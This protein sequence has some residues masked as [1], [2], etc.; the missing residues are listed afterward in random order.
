MTSIKSCLVGWIILFVFCSVGRVDLFSGQEKSWRENLPFEMPDLQPPDFPDQS[1]DIR[2]FGADPDDKIANTKAFRDAIAQCTEK[3]GGRV[4]VPPGEWLTGPIHLESNVDLHVAKDAV[5]K[6]ST[7]YA[8]YLPVVFISRGGVRCY[9]YSPPIYARDKENIAITGEGVIDGQ[10]QVWWPWKKKQPGMVKLFEMIKKDVPVK[11][12]VFGTVEDGVR[13]PFIHPIECKNVLIEG[14]TFKDGPSWNVHP[15]WCENVIIHDIKIVAHG[16]N[17]DGIDPDGC[18]NVLVENC[19]LDVGDDNI[20]L[21]SGRDEDAWAVGIPCEN[22]VVRNCIAKA[23]HG[24]IT[25]GSE[26]SAGVR[27][28]FVTDCDFDGTDRG[29]RL[30]TRLGRGGVVENIWIQNIT[31]RNIRMEAIRMNMHYSGEPIENEMNYGTLEKLPKD[32]PTFRNIYIKNVTCE[33]AKKAIELYGL[34]QNPIQTI[35]LENIHLQAQNRG[36]IDHV[37]GLTIK[38][39]SVKIKE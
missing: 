24:G 35:E 36:T 16:P 33:S 18:K 3:G 14:V 30:K 22:V 7:E 32:V 19:Y 26:M 11:E 23:G 6:F 25:I 29:I 28:V 13:P 15:V 5:I 27:N 4:L 17:N 2:D 34:P 1:F 31:M 12:R 10:G 8:D 37:E 20:C 38:D 21:K 9:T 39:F